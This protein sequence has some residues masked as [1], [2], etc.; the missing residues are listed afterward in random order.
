[1]SGK[2]RSST[3]ATL[4]PHEFSLFEKSWLRAS[5]EL[6]CLTGSFARTTA[7]FEKQANLIN[8]TVGACDYALLGQQAK[9]PRLM[10]L[11]FE[12]CDWTIFQ[13]VEHLRLHT[14]FVLNCIQSLIVGDQRKA[15]TPKLKYL[16][17]QQYRRITAA[18]WGKRLD[19]ASPVWAFGHQAS[20]RLRMSPS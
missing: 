16:I 6:R 13:V 9:I 14:E 4:M 1:M 8:S 3:D 15:P 17:R 10:G 18:S 19:S 5:F 12:S 11:R 7:R 20:A 2:V